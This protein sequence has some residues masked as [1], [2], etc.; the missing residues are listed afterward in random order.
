MLGC[1][2]HPEVHMYNL[3]NPI[4]VTKVGIEELHVVYLIA[5]SALA[6]SLATEGRG[7]GLVPQLFRNYIYLCNINS[8]Y[9]ENLQNS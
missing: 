3:L 4:P 9:A 2:I 6:A 7:E 1:Y 8:I 5:W